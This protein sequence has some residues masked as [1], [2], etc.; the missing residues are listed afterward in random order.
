MGF[1]GLKNVKSSGT[2]TVTKSPHGAFTM[3]S[4]L[5]YE[6]ANILYLRGKLEL[7]G[8]ESISIQ[9]AVFA[10]EGLSSGAFVD[11]DVPFSSYGHK[12]GQTARVYYA[13]G[14][15]FEVT[16]SQKSQ[17]LSGKAE[18]DAAV[19]GTVIEF[20]YHFDVTGLDT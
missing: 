6:R 10:K 8:T 11:G 4:I 16:Y 18:F 19:D 15:A 12:K 14:G 7:S 5:F 17:H 9:L 2:F 13:R 3:D 1:F 20:A